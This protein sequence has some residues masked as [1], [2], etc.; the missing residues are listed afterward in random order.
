M[1]DRLDQR[2]AASTEDKNVTGER[3]SSQTFLHLQ[4]QAPHPAAHIGV[5]RRDPDT[6][7]AGDRDHRNA[8]RAAVTNAAEACEPILNRTP[9]DNS[10]MIAVVSGGA[11][12]AGSGTITAGANAASGSPAMVCCRHL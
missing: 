7:T 4:C 3:I 11:A 1:P 10:T 8:R 12:A 9:L 5:T 6:R 2:T